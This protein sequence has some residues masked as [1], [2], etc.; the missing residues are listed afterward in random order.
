MST[1]CNFMH[2]F[3]ARRCAFYWG[4]IIVVARVTI[5]L[6]HING[7][8]FGGRDFYAS[9]NLDQRESV[10]TYGFV[11][12]D[13]FTTNSFLA[14]L[15]LNMNFGVKLCWFGCDLRHCL[16]VAILLFLFDLFRQLLLQR[17]LISPEAKGKL[18]EHTWQTTVLSLRPQARPCLIKP[19]L[20]IHCLVSSKWLLWD[21]IVICQR[22][23]KLFTSEEFVS[24]IFA[25]FLC[26]KGWHSLGRS[27]DS[28]FLWLIG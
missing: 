3:V 21:W 11:F 5:D 18:V 28:T 24:F 2:N 9:L 1:C 10:N 19:T 17:W 16:D 20:G 12:I 27:N 14:V 6:V 4:K 13:K 8:Y 23:L 7:L 26:S 22:A 25:R 15:A